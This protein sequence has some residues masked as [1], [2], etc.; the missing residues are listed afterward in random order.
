V[1]SG[2]S[3][4]FVSVLEMDEESNFVISMRIGSIYEEPSGLSIIILDGVLHIF[5]EGLTLDIV[6]I[7]GSYE[8]VAFDTHK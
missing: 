8:T 3:E 2:D 1:F 5:L 7:G 6:R 4:F